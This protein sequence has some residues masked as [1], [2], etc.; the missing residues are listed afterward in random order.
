MGFVVVLDPVEFYFM[1]KTVETS[2]KYLL[3]C[4]T[5][6]KSHTG[7]EGNKGG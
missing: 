3:L 5:E 7:L 1:A 2:L 4:C 6:E